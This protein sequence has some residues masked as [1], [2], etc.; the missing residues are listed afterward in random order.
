M[1]KLGYGLMTLTD[2]TE[3]IPISLV[4]ETSQN[5]QTKTGNLYEPNFE[6][7]GEE[8]IITPS[9]FQGAK[10]ISIP[11][12]VG[13]GKLYYQTGEMDTDGEIKYYYDGYNPQTASEKRAVWVD[14]TGAL[15]YQKNLT[16]NLTIEAYIDNYKNG[17]H[18]FTVELI[19]ASNPIQILFLEDN[20]GKYTA[21]I[22]SADGREHFEDGNFNDI[23]LTA[24]LYYGIDAFSEGVTY[25]WYKLSKP[26]EPFPSEE[27]STL[28]TITVSRSDVISEERFKCIITHE[29]TGIKYDT[30]FDIWDKTDEYDCIILSSDPLLLSEDNKTIILS[31][32]VFNKNGELIN[33][34][35]S[36][37]DLSYEWRIGESEEVLAT[38]KKIELSSNDDNIPKKQSFPI[39]CKVFLGQE[40]ESRRLITQEIETIQFVPAFTAKVTP[41][42]IFIPVDSDG[43]HLG[44]NWN[45]NFTFSLLDKAGKVM[46]FITDDPDVERGPIKGNNVTFEQQSSLWEFKGTINVENDWNQGWTENTKFLEFTYVYCGKTFTFGIMLIK[47]VKGDSNYNAFITSSSGSTLMSG[48]VSTVLTAHLYYGKQ[49]IENI[50]Y[51]W[52]KD[53]TPISQVSS[54]SEY[55]VEASTFTEKAIYSCDFFLSKNQQNLVATASY[56]LINLTQALP[57]SLIL[58]SNYAQHIQTKLGNFYEP[59]F[60][61]SDTQLKITPTLKVGQ[62]E[63]DFSK[64]SPESF[65]YGGTLKYEIE[66]SAFKTITIDKASENKEG[67]WVDGDGI[68]YCTQ[69]L[70][71]NITIEAYITNFTI[72]GV[73]YSTIQAMNPINFL[74]LEQGKETTV[75]TIASTR[76]YFDDKNATEIT[77]TASLM[78]PNST[79]LSYN[80]TKALNSNSV[81][82]NNTA[83]SITIQRSDIINQEI[84]S[85]EIKNETTGLTYSASKIIY[86]FTD[87]YFCEISYNK[88]LLLTE[89]NTQ[90]TLSVKVWDKYGNEVNTETAKLSYA[91]DT[92]PD[93]NFGAPIGTEKDFTLNT[94]D[95][96]TIPQKQTFTVYCRVYL[97]DSNDENT[98][99]IASDSVTF[100]YTSEYQAK[101][102]PS[103]IFIPTTSSGEYNDNGNDTTPKKYSFNFK[104][105]GADG[106]P[107]SFN[108]DSGNETRPDDQSNSD[109]TTI[110]FVGP[111]EDKW[112][113]DATINFDSGNDDYLWHTNNKSV[114]ARTYEFTYVYM[115]QTFTEEINI[116]KSYAGKEGQSFSGYTVDLSNS[117]HAFKGGEISADPNQNPVECIVTAYYGDESCEIE[118]IRLNSTTGSLIYSS[119]DDYSEVNRKNLFISATGNVVG[120]EEAI[121]LTF[122]PGKLESGELLTEVAPVNLYVKIKP[123]GGERRTIVKTFSYVI[124]YG[125]RSYYLDFNGNN[126]ITYNKGGTYTPSSLT[127]QALYRD[128]TNAP[129]T[130]SNGIIIY[131]KDNSSNWTLISRTGSGTISNYSNFQNLQVRLYKST[132]FNEKAVNTTITPT[133]IQ[134]NAAYLLDSEVIPVLTSM[135][136]YEIG[137]DNLIK[138]S[139][140]F[141][142]LDSSRWTI[143]DNVS[144]QSSL[145]FFEAVW[146]G[147]NSIYSPLIE[148]SSAYSYKDFCLS[149]DIYRGGTL[150]AYIF[151]SS[152]SDS[153]KIGAISTTS[154][155]NFIVDSGNGYKRAYAIFKLPSGIN[156]NFK[157]QFYGTSGLKIKKPKLEIGNIPSSWSASPYDIDYEDIVGANLIAGGYLKK[158]TTTVEELYDE[159]LPNTT[160]TL[161]WGSVEPANTIL[162]FSLNGSSYSQKTSPY[163][164]NSGSSSTL[165]WCADQSATVKQIKLEKGSK[166]TDFVFTEDQLTSFFSNSSQGLQGI[167]G[168]QGELI[169]DMSGLVDG[170]GKQISEQNGT[171]TLLNT[172]VTDSFELLEQKI[173][174]NG[175]YNGD[176]AIILTAESFSSGKFELAL[177]NN[178]LAFLEGNKEIAYMSNQELFI[179]HAQITESLRIGNIKFIPTTTGTALIVAK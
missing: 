82:E 6:N 102:T 65:P 114:G 26:N 68:L 99:Q 111:K 112:D 177:T 25:Q 168:T 58:K 164:F 90:V 104:L 115:G 150:T 98:R 37:V 45:Y 78:G 92:I 147:T 20:S 56:T 167:I 64:L 109:G 106:N 135:E 22:T 137:G 18:G 52:K 74:L 43:N 39:F 163:T 136:G 123:P 2:L 71:A 76:E 24:S 34:E 80:W 94:S 170:L 165:F 59:N 139:K 100:Q 51:Q 103:T 144:I 153:S 146:S 152:N 28:S 57:V 32:N 3:T 63:V 127:V 23:T 79:D 69:N 60:N 97:S 81:I 13:D 1:A 118:E 4:L 122:K 30:T 154:T 169:T 105:L 75:A 35:D 8:L 87:E 157:V 160:Y 19:Q 88:P 85:C 10:E 166:V 131:R 96:S 53:G 29:E 101:V 129:A 9:L 121:K 124:N 173:N 93:K 36:S 133:E 44:S 77:L 61:N 174:L 140:T 49:S 62:T 42:E 89:E 116:I 54:S 15:H 86:D 41:S 33:G 91:W 172:K 134:S 27:K 126:T 158:I 145:D 46:P 143:G 161:S 155:E 31:V 55:T 70:P 72:Q 17:E 120:Q 176:Q 16:Q 141:S 110:T 179:T 151:N 108:N 12:G 125:G 119:S 113:F 107:I 171:L 162:S 7:K 83:Q 142:S 47:N 149:F 38:T 138:W 156:S 159:L 128:T 73:N 130:Y 95:T 11:L 50:Y 14:N 117:F 5:I 178:R 21:I 148:Y 40:E 67:F 132:A 48:D 66:S 175:E 84:Y